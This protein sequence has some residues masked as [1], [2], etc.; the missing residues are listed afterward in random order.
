MRTKCIIFPFYYFI[1]FRF[2]NVSLDIITYHHCIHLSVEFV[3][4]S[5][6]IVVDSYLALKMPEYSKDYRDH[7]IT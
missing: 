4:N 6:K 2:L 3:V 5:Y 1:V 7:A